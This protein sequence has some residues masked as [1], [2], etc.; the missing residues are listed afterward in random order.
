M[1]SKYKH[2]Y[3]QRPVIHMIWR[4]K[5]GGQ[6]T[7]GL[8]KADL[9][10]QGVPEPSNDCQWTSHLDFMRPARKCWCFTRFLD[11][12]EV[13]L[14]LVISKKHVTRHAGNRTPS[15]HMSCKKIAG[16]ASLDANISVK[17]NQVRSCG[18]AVWGQS[19]I[20]AE[21]STCSQHAWS[22]VC[23]LKAH[24]GPTTYGQVIKIVFSS[25]K[26]TQERLVAV[27]GSRAGRQSLIEPIFCKCPGLWSAPLW[28][29][30][31]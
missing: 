22:G 28:A 6:S 24:I 11:L 23:G 5:I 30:N 18:Q 19:V 10:L 3:G 26:S 16:R 15:G 4:T 27:L 1:H 25:S 8:K 9:R 17:G 20:V 29:L 7:F 2:K 21:D 31:D 13:A 14:L 12:N